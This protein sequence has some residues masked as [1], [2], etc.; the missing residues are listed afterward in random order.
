ME[1]AY[2]QGKSIDR[3]PGGL[4]LSDQLDEEVNHLP[5]GG[6]LFE[7]PL[8]DLGESVRDA[9][10]DG[11]RAGSSH[12]RDRRGIGSRRR[13]G[14]LGTHFY[15]LAFTADNTDALAAML[16]TAGAKG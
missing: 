5:L 10:G 2:M 16:S 12:E 3:R 4:H 9:G 1:R 8:F 6:G 15:S 14:S 7:Q 13:I 11:D